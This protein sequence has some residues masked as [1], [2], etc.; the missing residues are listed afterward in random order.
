MPVLLAAGREKMVRDFDKKLKLT[1]M[2]LRCRTAK[3]L[4]QKFH[5]HGTGISFELQ[6]FYKWMQGKST[7][8]ASQVYVSWAQLLELDASAAFLGSCS[9]AQF[10]DMIVAGDRLDRA[11]VDNFL[12]QL[13][14]PRAN[15]NSGDEGTV[16]LGWQGAMKGSYLCYSL[17]LTF[18]D[19]HQVIRGLLKLD[20]GAHPDSAMHA[21]YVEATRRVA[22]WHFG[23]ATRRR[24]LIG[25]DVSDRDNRN[26]LYF[27]LYSPDTPPNFLFGHK[28]GASY[29]E[30][31]PHPNISRVLAIRLPAADAKGTAVD[32]APHFGPLEGSIVED[33][34]LAGLDIAPSQALER[35]LMDTLSGARM[36]SVDRLSI[37]DGK[38]LNEILGGRCTKG[39]RRNNVATVT[40]RKVE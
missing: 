14:G 21:H 22:L 34:I 12:Q 35:T 36:N 2:A 5:G 15:L 25:I 39:R 26:D 38:R 20:L 17:A 11:S 7:P 10:G 27:N 3:E 30:A 40:E 13:A 9:I 28:A 16:S 24:R 29:E 23:A 31:V 18:R 6:S 8:R 4:Y 19:H 37:Q 33:L 32:Q 1:A